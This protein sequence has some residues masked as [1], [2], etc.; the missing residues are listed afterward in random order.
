MFTAYVEKNTPMTT[1]FSVAKIVVHLPDGLK[2]ANLP[3]GTKLYGP[4][5]AA[6]IGYYEFLNHNSN[7]IYEDQ[8]DHLSNLY[9][10]QS[11]KHRLPT[12]QNIPVPKR[13]R[14]H[15]HSKPSTRSVRR[16]QPTAHRNYKKKTT[17]PNY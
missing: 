13:S 12:Q 17:K 15:P 1:F 10:S 14:Y 9:P 2:R 7:V 5:V 11:V 6:I 4:C 3:D 8:T 16:T